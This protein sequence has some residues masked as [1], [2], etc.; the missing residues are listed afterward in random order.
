MK[1]ITRELHLGKLCF[2]VAL[3]LSINFTV[4][5]Q[6]EI[7][8]SKKITIVTKKIDKDGKEIVENQKIG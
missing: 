8:E 7:K 1:L 2:L 6:E 4:T 5:A 3:F